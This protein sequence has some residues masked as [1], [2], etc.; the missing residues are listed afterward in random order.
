MKN[1]KT[2]SS[3]MISIC[4]WRIS[5]ALPSGLNLWFDP[6]HECPILVGVGTPGS[7]SSNDSSNLCVPWEQLMLPG[8]LTYEGSDPEEPRIGNQRK[9]H[10]QMEMPF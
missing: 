4:N 8:V 3:A 6:L 10:R 9:G 5:N 2:F 1:E 7:R